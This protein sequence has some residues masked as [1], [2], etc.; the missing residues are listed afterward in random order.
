MEVHGID[1]MAGAYKV[2]FEAGGRRIRGLVPET[3]VS[4]ALKKM[5][6]PE[7]VDVYQWIA[8]HRPEIE[9]ALLAMTQ[10]EARR[11]KPPYDRLSLVEET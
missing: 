1:M 10:G 8:A 11:V 2:S 9:N 3:L 5:G 4:E 7:H 6:R